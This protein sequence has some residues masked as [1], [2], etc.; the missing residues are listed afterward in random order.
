VAD[1]ASRELHHL[2]VPAPNNPRGIVKQCM[3]PL[4]TP[5]RRSLLGGCGLQVSGLQACKLLRPQLCCTCVFSCHEHCICEEKQTEKKKSD[6]HLIRLRHHVVLELSLSGSG[7]HLESLCKRDVS[8]EP[9]IQDTF[10]FAM[11]CSGG[12][13]CAII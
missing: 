6:S 3:A 7:S 1:V 5:L 11:F 9:S 4:E 12:S 13:R 8:T 10:V 2:V